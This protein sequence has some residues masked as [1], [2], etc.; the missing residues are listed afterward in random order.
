MNR[1]LTSDRYQQDC[2]IPLNKIN[3]KLLQL[4]LE[5]ASLDPDKYSSLAPDACGG[6][7]VETEHRKA[8]WV[9]MYLQALLLEV[10]MDTMPNIQACE[11]ASSDLIDFPSH[12][13]SGSGT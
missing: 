2:M 11:I 6:Q 1:A 9:K 7:R 5:N 8:K 13:E 3:Y 4:A 12:S 10:D